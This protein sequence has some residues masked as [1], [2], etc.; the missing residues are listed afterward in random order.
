MALPLIAAS[1][2]AKFAVA[3]CACALVIPARLIW[4]LITIPITIFTG[5]DHTADWGD[6]DFMAAM[7]TA[8]FPNK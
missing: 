3:I 1:Y 2:I 6:G 4:L 8:F 5:N 7:W